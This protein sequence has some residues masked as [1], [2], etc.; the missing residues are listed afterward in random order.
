M[1]LIA[2]IIVELYAGLQPIKGNIVDFLNFWDGNWDN[3]LLSNLE[4]VTCPLPTYPLGATAPD[5]RL[6]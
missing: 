4:V 2:P 1:S 3:N 5:A 6:Q